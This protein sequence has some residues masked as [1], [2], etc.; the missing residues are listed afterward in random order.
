M[1]SSPTVDLVLLFQCAPPSALSA[2]AQPDAAAD[3]AIA[4]EY[5][6]L[7]SAIRAAGFRFTA[8]PG[9][10]KG[11]VLLFVKAEEQALVRCRRAEQ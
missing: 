3:S 6:A 4:S 2:G 9:A 1:S 7:V 5:A 10:D 8:R 11:T